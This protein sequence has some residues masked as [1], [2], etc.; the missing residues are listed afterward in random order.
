MLNPSK[1]SPHVPSDRVSKNPLDFPNLLVCIL[2]D[3]V[4]DGYIHN[5]YTQIDQITQKMINFINKEDINYN[6]H[7]LV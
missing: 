6:I 1:A 3:T 7:I 4:S 2:N 5:I